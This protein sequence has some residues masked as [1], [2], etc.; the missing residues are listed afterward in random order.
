MNTE[1]NTKSTSDKNDSRRMSDDNKN[2]ISGSGKNSRMSASSGNDVKGISNS[3]KSGYTKDGSNGRSTNKPEMKSTQCEYHKFFV[4]AL[5]DI[6]WA[7]QNLIKGL[8][9]MSKAATS[10]KLAAAFDKHIAESDKQTAV[11]EQVFELLGEKP[12]TKRCAAMAGLLEEADSAIADTEKNSFVRDA[13]LIMASQK[14]EHYEIATYGTLA[15]LAEYLPEKRVAK[16]L[17][18]ILVGEKKTDGSLTKLAEE[19]I[20]EY[21]AV[22]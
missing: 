15:A 13:A 7:E 20:N 16:L 4:D 22:E 1:K 18:R 17:G 14:A 11:I 21:A 5:K 3:G 8:R 19:F 2:R 9:K 10:P 6:Y 12:A